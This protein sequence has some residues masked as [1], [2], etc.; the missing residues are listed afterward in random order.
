MLAEMDSAIASGYKPGYVAD[1]ILSAVVEGKKELIISPITPW[2]AIIIR[3][4]APS[5][6]FWIM[7][8]RAENTSN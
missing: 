2:L 5:L 7:E 6:Y 1:K 4:F 3:T 8:R